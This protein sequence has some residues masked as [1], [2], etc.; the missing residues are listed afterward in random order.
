MMP[1][2]DHPS[3][4]SKERT[5]SQLATP[6]LPPPER[7]KKPDKK[8]ETPVLVAIISASVTLITA[9]LGSP[10]FLNLVNK[11]APPASTN[12][13]ELAISQSS[14]LPNNPP[15]GELF[16]I[17][18]TPTDSG[19][20][21]LESTLTP[22]AENLTSAT[23]L[24]ATS[25]TSPTLPPE[26]P[27]PPTPAAP[28]I[29][30]CIAA[31]LWTTYPSTLKSE[32][33]DGCLNL[34]EWG[35]ST[36][37]G[38]LLLVPKPVQDQQRGIYTPISGDVDISFSIQLNEFRTRL[39]KVGFLHFGI[40]QNNPFS[41][42]KGGYLSYQQP[43]PGTDSPIRVLISGSNQATQKISVLDVGFQHDVLLSI[44]DNL[45]TV[46]LNGKQTGDPVSLPR[47]GRA[48]WIGYV[49]PSKS[50]LDVMI[51]NFTIQTH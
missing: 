38:R 11:P 10:M 20:D 34:A 43:T 27:K 31:D 36:D 9:I 2:S 49:L 45:M 21:I 1:D 25:S 46:Y 32:I 42:Y 26:I 3:L 16:K 12:A 47:T 19:T 51:T 39:N 48:F 6:A 29:F 17:Q 5:P 15:A 18:F 24:L 35:F 4:S 44:K 40:V 13:A 50:E 37:Q 14:L 8:L 7:E 22:Q 28:S 33:S 41:I 23:P 30:Q